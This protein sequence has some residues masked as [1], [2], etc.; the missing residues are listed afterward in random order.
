M[1]TVFLDSAE[2]A[3][4]N[5]ERPETGQHAEEFAGFTTDG[6]AFREYDLVVMHGD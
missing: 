1:W 3:A 5:N 4:R 2:D 6:I